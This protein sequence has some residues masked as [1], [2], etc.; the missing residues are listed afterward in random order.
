[1]GLGE[2]ERQI[3]SG[4][5]PIPASKQAKKL[6]ELDH[7]SG[8]GESVTIRLP[9]VQKASSNPTIRLISG[10]KA[11]GTSTIIPIRVT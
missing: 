7:L 11:Y 1:M 5:G 8:G 6:N 2:N 9:F 4:P 10:G 3:G